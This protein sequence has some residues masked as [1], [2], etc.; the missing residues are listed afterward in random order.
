MVID[1]H[2][3]LIVHDKEL[4]NPSVKSWAELFAGAMLTGFITRETNTWVR[5]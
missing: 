4:L 1:T 5:L 3:H 2:C